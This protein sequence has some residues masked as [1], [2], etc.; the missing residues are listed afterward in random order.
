MRRLEYGLG[1]LGAGSNAVIDAGD[2]ARS[3]SSSFAA[4]A[5]LLGCCLGQDLASSSLQARNQRHH[6]WE[7][8]RRDGGSQEPPDKRFRADEAGGEDCPRGSSPPSASST[9][10]G[11]SS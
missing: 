3:D 8:S 6:A 2:A 1:A 4:A 9:A 5:S 7:I 10:E 11:A